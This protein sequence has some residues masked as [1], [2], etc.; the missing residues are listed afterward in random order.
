MTEEQKDMEMAMVSINEDDTIAE[1]ILK[2]QKANVPAEIV[3]KVLIRM[4]HTMDELKESTLELLKSK[5]GTD[6]EGEC[7]C[8]N[9]KKNRI[10]DY[11]Q[12][13][14]ADGKPPAEI[15]IYLLEAG[16][17]QKLIDKTVSGL[18]K[19]SK[20]LLNSLSHYSS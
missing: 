13:S 15:N 2:F 14:F 18:K 12:A 4:G 9:C 11:L 7:Q 3:A 20:A 5:M 16:Y 19:R 1:K 6:F 10:A 17:S 8:K